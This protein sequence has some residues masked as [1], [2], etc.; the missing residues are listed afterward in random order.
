MT[1]TQLSSVTTATT[2]RA[3]RAGG[4]KLD[5]LIRPHFSHPAPLQVGQENGLEF[6]LPPTGHLHH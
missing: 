3:F 4:R 6:A 5:R 1:E 2:A